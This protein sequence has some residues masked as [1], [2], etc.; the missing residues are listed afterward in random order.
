MNIHTVL[1]QECH[2]APPP[3]SRYEQKIKL[4][5]VLYFHRI[6]DVRMS[7]TP[8]KNF[9]MF[10]KLCGESALRNVVIVTNMWGGVDHQVGERREAEL[11][12]KDKFFK[13]VLEKHAQMTRHEDTIESAQR[14]L[15]LVLHNHPLP[16]RIQVELVD[17]G[18]ELHE[19]SAGEELNQELSAQIRKHKKDM[20]ALEEQMQQ[21]MRDK[22]EEIRM[23]LEEETKKMWDDIKKA[24]NEAER[25]AEK[26]R[27]EREGA[28]GGNWLHGLHPA[29]LPGAVVV[30]TVTLLRSKIGPFMSTVTCG[31]IPA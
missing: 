27:R 28:F 12:G 7:G 30:G 24:Q 11:K 1:M 8:V 25:L 5:G 18:K 21:A 29:I 23:E 3:L 17:E 9:K 13:P 10:R 2:V 15:R 4:A 16:L 31:V 6:S 14:I 20:R 19:T 22:D 26:R